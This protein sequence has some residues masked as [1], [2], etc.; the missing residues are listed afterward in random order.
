MGVCL[1][2]AIGCDFCCECPKFVVCSLVRPANLDE[3]FNCVLRTPADEE[4]EK[5]KYKLVLHSVLSV[6]CTISSILSFHRQQIEDTF[7]VMVAC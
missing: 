2:D 5:V 1:S 4:N 3:L 7:I 6:C